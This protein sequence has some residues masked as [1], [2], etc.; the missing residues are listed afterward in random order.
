MTEFNKNAS[1]NVDDDD[2]DEKSLLNDFF[3]EK[4]ETADDETS[5]EIVEI[6]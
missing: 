6:N 2:G 5:I 3:E 4:N 1:M